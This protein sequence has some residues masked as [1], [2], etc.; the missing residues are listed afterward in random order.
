MSDRE[1]HDDH[2][3]TQLPQIDLERTTAQRDA[4]HRMITKRQKRQNGTKTATKTHKQTPKRQK[5]TNI[6]T[7][8]RERQERAKHCRNNHRDEQTHTREPDRNNEKPNS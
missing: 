7:K 4:R 1:K 2:N 5:S 3:G 6:S 8:T